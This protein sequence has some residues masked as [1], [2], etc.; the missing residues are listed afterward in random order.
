MSSPR[1]FDLEAFERCLDVYG[2]DLE[3]WPPEQRSQGRVLLS[4]SEPA[5][6][7]REEALELE[8]VLAQAPGIEPSARL[9]RSVLE[10]PTRESRART[11]SSRQP[12]TSLWV[13]AA[14]A[15]AALGWVT[16][17]MAE[18][19]L[20]GGEAFGSNRASGEIARDGALEDVGWTE[21]EA[22]ELSELAFALHLEGASAEE[23]P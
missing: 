7:L 2:A 3:H 4:S 5:R 21:Q 12:P 22:E 6:R 13:F 15:V 10:I 23:W 16:G 18:Q 1:E 14:A 8:T 20:G 19:G 9:L 17:N 11:A